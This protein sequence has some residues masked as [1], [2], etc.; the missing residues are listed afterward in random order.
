MIGFLES[1]RRV[2]TC[3]KKANRLPNMKWEIKTVFLFMSFLLLFHMFLCRLKPLYV[4]TV[5]DLLFI[6]NCETRTRTLTTRKNIKYK[7]TKHNETKKYYCEWSDQPTLGVNL[8]RKAWVNKLRHA[9]W[10]LL[11]YCE[12]HIFQTFV[13]VNVLSTPRY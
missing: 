4:V 11:P 5:Y 9:I 2:L 3:M 13:F 12:S 6:S 8:D 1:W 7:S 10:N